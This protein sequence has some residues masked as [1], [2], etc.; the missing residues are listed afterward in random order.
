[1][2]HR[3]LH[4]R[5]MYGLPRKFN[6]AFD[7]GASISALEDT[8]DIGFVTDQE[9]EMLKASAAHYAAL[10]RRYREELHPL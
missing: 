3:I 7:G 10:G 5:E 4:N 8:N 9:V 6:I 2:H 1:M